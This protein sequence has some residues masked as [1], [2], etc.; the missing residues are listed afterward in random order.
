MALPV[1]DMGVLGIA[2]VNIVLTVILV[3]F[4]YRN[5]MLIRSKM[6]AGML[7]FAGAFLLENLMNF[8]FYESLLASGI[9]GI[10][11]FHFAVNFIEM[12]GILVLLYVTWR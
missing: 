4:F 5:H 9:F 7:F 8:Y 6:T 10:T 12:I 2:F 11:A 3:Y 1:W